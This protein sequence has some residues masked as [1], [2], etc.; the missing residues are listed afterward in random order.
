MYV[1][2]LPI[3]IFSFLMACRFFLQGCLR[4]NDMINKT[5]S[6]KKGGHLC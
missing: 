3:A 6:R 1:P 2:Y 4:V 5:P